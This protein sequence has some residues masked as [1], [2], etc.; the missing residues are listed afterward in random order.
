M[1]TGDTIFYISRKFNTIELWKDVTEKQWNDANWQLK[2]SIKSVE[3]LKQVIKLN[4]YQEKEIERTLITLKNEG[5]EPLRI[6]PY[7]A[8][9][10]Q[11]DPFHPLMLPGEKQNKRLDPI[12]WQSVPTPANLLFPD[13]GVEGAMSEDSR[14]FGAV[15]QRYPNRVALFVAENTSCASYCVHCQR[16]KS[17]DGSVDVNTTEINKGLFYIG[18]N[19]NINE[20]LVTGGDALMISK[21]RLQYILEELSKIAHLRV[22]RIATRVPVVLPMGITDELLELINVSSNK[23]NEG[24]DKYVYFMTH[25]NHYQEIT[26]E[27]ALAVKKIRDHGFTIRNQT[28]FLNHVNDYYKTLAE[29]FRRMFWIGIHPYYLLQ[30]HKEKGIVHFITP[31]QIGKIYMKHLQGWI[32]GITIPRYAANIEGGGGKVLLMPS[33]HDTLDL[34]N[35]VDNKISESFATVSTWDG[36]ELYKYEALG[37]TTYNE[38]E[39]GVRIM[40]DFIGRKGVFVPKLIII[41]DEGNHIETTNR[42]K[43]PKLEKI[44][45]SKLLGYDLFEKDM[46]LTNPTDISSELDKQFK[47]SIYFKQE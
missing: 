31:I 4:A 28:V 37:R 34:G 38:F 24:P 47:K 23:Y 1:L 32:S 21:S 33:G 17:L 18:Q 46:P 3:Q 16:A 45:K 19:K 9:L 10:M 13:T 39:N 35:N 8:S 40:D 6:T 36:R 5:K 25:I 2:N 11:A 7:Y 14:S 44:K 27:L 41:D 15:Y 26:E 22:I 43:L 20:V 29:T 12:F 42:T 30:C